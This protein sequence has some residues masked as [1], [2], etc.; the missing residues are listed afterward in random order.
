MGILSFFSKTKQRQS[1]DRYRELGSYSAH[2]VR[3]GKDPYQSEIVRS[4]VRPLAEFTSKAQA[5][6]SDPRLERL[7]N[8]R[9]NQFMSGRDF[10]QK[11]RI[12]TELRNTCFIYIQ[13]DNRGGVSGLYPV[14]YAGFE[15][16]EY[17]NG[18]FVKFT[19]N[20]E[21]AR[22]LVLPWE[23]LAVIRRDYYM[24]DIA[25]EENGAILNT[26][27]MI[28]TMEQGLSNAVK[29]TANL[30]GI[31]KST[32]TMLSPDDVRKQKEQFVRDYLS[33]ENEG[34]IASLDGTQEF[35]PISMSP[36][37]ATYDQ[38]K[39]YR[40][41]V[42]RYFGVNDNIVM[43]NMTAEQVETFYEL[44]IEPFLSQL[45]AEL[46]SKVFTKRE[47]NFDN[48]IIFEQNKLAFASLDKKI[49]LFSTV[50]LY[51]G[52]T[53]N[54]WRLACNMVPIEGGDDRVMRLD[55]GTV[56]ESTGNPINRREDEEENEE[57]EAD[58]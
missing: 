5:R 3:F 45:S 15:G 40:E 52:M 57:G 54:E 7:L 31:L 37:T 19:F 26:L 10:L 36:I 44:K 14:P 9:P 25:G 17:G 42:Y 2:F 30:R 21:A 24:G 11:I 13:R 58:G 53:V 34:G 29:A 50:V 27:Q 46:T 55:A 8:N 39:E 16:M 33:L 20:G 41:N 22:Q 51:G 6:C 38:V 35:T 28:S 48:W 49:K 23:D 4:C 43:G 32:K 18:L 1:Y 56:D 12:I 47:L